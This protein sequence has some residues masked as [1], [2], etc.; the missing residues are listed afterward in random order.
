MIPPP[1]KVVPP[2]FRKHCPFKGRAGIGKF[3]PLP[4]GSL[5]V[6]VSEENGQNVDF[7]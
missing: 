3:I 1:T 7:H 5:Y 2:F 6:R 4:I